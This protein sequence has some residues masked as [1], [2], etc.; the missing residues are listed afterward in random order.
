MVRS[1][2]E[3]VHVIGHDHVPTNGN[4][5]L[6][7]RARSE[8]YKRGVHRVRCKQFSPLLGAECDKEQGIV[9][10]DPSQARRQFWIFTHANLLAASLWE[11][12]CRCSL[13]AR[14]VAHRATATEVGMLL[15]VTCSLKLCGEESKLSFQWIR[16]RLSNYAGFRV[17]CTTSPTNCRAR[18]FPGL[19]RR[20]GNRRSTPIDATRAFES[21]LTS[22]E[23]IVR[24]SI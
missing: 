11:A 13:A 3:K 20:R 22:R 18:N 8:R 21:V 2:D 5:L 23:S 9:S 14:D 15:R 10:E 12:Q 16:S 7:I 1:A 19:R 6:R 4:I 17:R 24:R